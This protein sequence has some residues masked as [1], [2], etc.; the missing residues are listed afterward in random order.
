MQSYFLKL[1]EKKIKI[2]IQFVNISKLLDL[3][4]SVTLNHGVRTSFLAFLGLM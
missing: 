1:Q 2:L 4:I 3:I